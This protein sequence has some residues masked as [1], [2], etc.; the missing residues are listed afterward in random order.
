MMSG[1]ILCALIL[2]SSAHALD[3][4]KTKQQVAQEPVPVP[5]LD[6]MATQPQPPVAQQPVVPTTQAVT[7]AI[8]ASSNT[9]L[10]LDAP[11]VTVPAGAGSGSGP[12]SDYSLTSNTGLKPQPQHVA[13]ATAQP[14]TRNV[15]KLAFGQISDLGS[16][17]HQ[18]REDDQAHI[19]QLGVDVHL[20]DHLKQELH[21]AE[22]RLEH[23]NGELA[24]ETTGIVPAT[25]NADVASPQNGTGDLSA[26][27]VQARSVKSKAETD[28]I[29]LS[30]ARDVKRLTDDMIELHDRDVGEVKALRGNAQTR[31]A[32]SDQIAREREQLVA[33]SSGLAANLGQIQELVA[34]SITVA[35]GD[36]PTAA[37]SSSEAQIQQEAPATAA[38]ET[39]ASVV[40]T[41]A[42][43]LP[44]AAAT[45]A[46]LR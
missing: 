42:T 9:Q 33:D 11:Q 5:V 34:P 14:Q 25:P 31:S 2:T 18:L 37:T 40:A 27:L 32:L 29:A 16:E 46:W 1:L 28:A 12:G 7:D 13:L 8:E 26:A 10:Q 36:S 22:E 43:P 3:L 21:E 38:Q 30:T 19:K 4:I 6:L 17:F 41:P 39:V 45:S 15:T 24:Q 44:E 23:D 20:R 35:A